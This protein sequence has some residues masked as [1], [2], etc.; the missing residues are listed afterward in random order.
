MNWSNG[1]A[2]RAVRQNIYGLSESYDPDRVHTD[3]DA[4]QY[5]T[6]TYQDVATDTGY[7][8]GLQAGLSDVRLGRD[9]KPEKHEAYENAKH[10]YRHEY[11]DKGL[12]VEQ[13]RKAFLR[14]YEDA[15]NRRSPR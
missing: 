14:G 5:A 10:G 4:D 6:W 15:A 3:A 2:I 12:Y 11:G 1:A 8:D 9:F 13:Y 7:S